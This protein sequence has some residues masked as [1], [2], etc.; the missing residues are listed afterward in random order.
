MNAAIGVVCA[1]RTAP[2]APGEL[3]MSRTANTSA[4]VTVDEPNIDTVRPT[5]SQR[6]RLSRNGATL[7]TAGP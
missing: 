7:S 3:E 4:M 2:N 1:A 6:K 5:N